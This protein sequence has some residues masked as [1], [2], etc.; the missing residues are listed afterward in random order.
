MI[1]RF[2]CALLFAISGLVHAAPEVG[3]PAPDFTAKG[4]DGKTYK[5]S[6]FKGKTVVLEWFNK[7][8]P[9]V[10]KFYDSKT[11][12]GLQKENTG[13]GIV[14]LTIVSSA[15]GKEGYVN[16]DAAKKVRTEVGMSSTASGF[17]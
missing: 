12:Q 1:R 16:P 14:W 6:E 3:K 4:A 15:K 7:D 13:K 8:C 2:I 10:H 11:M 9:Y 17:T 5:L